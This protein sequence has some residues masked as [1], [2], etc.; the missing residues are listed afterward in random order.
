M[1]ERVNK[2][3]ISLLSRFAA[4]IG[5][6]FIFCLVFSACPAQRRNSSSPSDPQGLLT[7]TDSAGASSDRLTLAEGVRVESLNGYSGFYVEDGSNEQCENVAAVSL[8]NDSDVDYQYLTF[9]VATPSGSCR[10]IASSLMAHSAMTVLAQEKAPF[11]ESEILS[12]TAEQIAPFTQTPSLHPDMVELTYTDGFINV[13]NLT[14]Q[15]LR[16]LFV[17]YKSTAGEDYFGGITYRVSVDEL[18]PGQLMQ[19]HAAN[20]HKDT[21]KMLFVTFE[22]PAE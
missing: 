10:F 4:A 11:T 21:S 16:H 6:L 14:D 1:T 15:T 12:V 3:A 19:K 20:I 2:N 8:V 5:I 7:D 17:Y 22:E 18:A 9:S 13:K